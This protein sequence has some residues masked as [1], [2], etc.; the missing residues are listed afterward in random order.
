M[1]VCAGSVSGGTMLRE[2]RR[3]VPGE[4]DDFTIRDLTGLVTTA[5]IIA[6]C[7]KR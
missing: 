7:L 1:D 6:K 4:E 3:I 5:G 2:R